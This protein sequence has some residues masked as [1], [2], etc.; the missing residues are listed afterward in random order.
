MKKALMI[1]AIVAII[2]VTGSMTYYFIFFRPE[3]ERA[4]IKLQEEKFEFEKE[5][6]ATEQ[7][8]IEQ[9][10]KEAIDKKTSLVNA[11]ASLEEWYNDSLNQAYKSYSA[12][13]EKACKDLGLKFISPPESWLPNIIAETLTEDYNQT[14]K[15]I[16]SQNESYKEDIYKLYE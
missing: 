4:E 13:W 10:E 3:K 15:R 14:I 2:A 1:I 9:K 11:L 16:Q 5:Q 6:K 7:I 12:Q 8:K